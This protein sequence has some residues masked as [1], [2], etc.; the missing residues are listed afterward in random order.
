MPLCQ[1]REENGLT[2]FARDAV[3]EPKADTL[4]FRAPF[5]CLDEQS[6]VQLCTYKDVIRTNCSMETSM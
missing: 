2:F 5:I 4:L 1:S 3:E 6:R